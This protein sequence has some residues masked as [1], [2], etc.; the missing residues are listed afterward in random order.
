[1]RELR[2]S[3]LCLFAWFLAGNS[4][5]DRLVLEKEILVR[6][7]CE[8]NSQLP[9]CARNDEPNEKL[10]APPRLRIPPP[11]PSQVSHKRRDVPSGPPKDRPAILLMPPTGPRVH[12][13]E[14]QVAGIDD[15]EDRTHIHIREQVDNFNRAQRPQLTLAQAQ[16]LQRRCSKIAPVAQKNCVKRHVLKENVARC[17]AYFRDCSPFL[18]K[19]SPLYSIANQWSS[20]VGLNLGSWS[21][22]GLPY[23]PVNEEGTIGAGHLV[24]IPFGSWGG[25]FGQNI[26]VRDYWS[27]W[28]EAGAN[29]YEGKY[30]Y[31]NGWSVPLVQ[32]LGVE[33]GQHN[34]VGVP[35]DKEHLG[36]VNV[37]N[38]YG[39][40]GY[41]GIN[42]H[43]GVNWKRGDVSNIFGVGSP[44]V[45]AGFM[46]GQALT[47]PSL[48]TWMPAI[49]K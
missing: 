30:G 43:V 21:V 41:F 39:V 49:G 3:L 12:P 29:W 45:G 23:Y 17:Q 10:V 14:R 15:R 33:G 28:Q 2:S 24:N 1:M 46:T 47:F 35:L 36:E 11:I 32:S 34:V 44:F 6:R 4:A 26:G 13:S 7:A 9:I 38:G 31:K 25:G 42:D 8:V 37:D 20:G 48:D 18:T 19:A 40:G 5:D 16:E 22:K 27:Q